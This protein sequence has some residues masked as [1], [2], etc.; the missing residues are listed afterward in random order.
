MNRTTERHGSAFFFLATPRALV[1]CA[2]LALACGLAS[3]GESP[4]AGLMGRSSTTST[5]EF[6]GRDFGGLRFPMRTV[7]GPVSFGAARVTTWSRE[8]PAT[9][10]TVQQMLLAGDVKVTLGV[11]RFSAAR[12]VVFIEKI[13]DA[14]D[15][16][17]AEDVPIPFAP[18]QSAGVYQIYVYFDRVSSPMAEISVSVQ[19]NRLPVRAVIE[20]EDGIDLRY[21]LL[22]Q[23]ESND[24]LVAEAERALANILRQQEGAET[25]ATTTPDFDSRKRLS[26]PVPSESR[27][28]LPPTANQLASKAAEDMDAT[29]LQNVAFT[30]PIFA[31]DGIFT[32]AP[33]DVTLISGTE[34]NSLLISNGLVVQYADTRSGRTLQLTAQRG[35]VFTDPTEIKDMGRLRASDVRGFYL[36][37]DVIASDGQYTLR[38]PKMFYDVRR[39]KA[40]VLDGVFW[41]YDQ[42]RKLPLYVRADTIRQKS[43]NE[44]EAKRARLASSAFFNPDFSIGTTTVTLT[45]RQVVSKPDGILPTVQSWTSGGQGSGSA[46][47]GA[48]APGQTTGARGLATVA[49]AGGVGTVPTTGY[50]METD[51]IT[52]SALMP[53]MVTEN[54]IDAKNITLN[55]EGFPF[56]YWPYYEGTIDEPLLRDLQAENRTGS[57]FAIKSRW[58]AYR[59][60]GLK[61]T[62]FTRAD[63][64]LDAYFSRG[65]GL[66]TNLA[67]AGPDANGSALMYGLFNDHGTDVLPTG[68]RHKYD[69]ENRGIVLMDHALALND[70]WT[71]LGEGAYQSDANFVE[72]FYPEMAQTRREFTTE[73]YLR[74]LEDNTEFT[75]N[76]KG[77]TNSFITNEYLLQ[78]QGYYVSKAPELQ[79][80]RQADPLLSGWFGDVLTWTQEYRAGMMGMK[81]DDVT[82]SYRGFSNPALSQQ[83]FGIDPNQTLAQSLQ[84]QGN[85][86]QQV[87]RFDTRQ[88]V[89]AKIEMGPVNFVPY[90]VVRLTGYDHNF[91]Q[92]SNNAGSTD[93][94]RYRLWGA[95]GGTLSTQIQRVDNSADSRLF[96]IHRVRHI[97]EPSMT[98]FTAATNRDSSTLPTYDENVEAIAKG[99]S[100][101]AGVNQIWQTQRGSP[102]H[103][104]SVD[105]FTLDANYVDSTSSTDTRSPVG[106]FFDFRPEL[107]SFGKYGNLDSAWRVTDA[108]TLTGGTVYDF[109]LNQQAR[110]SAGIIVQQTPDVTANV[111]FRYLNALDLTTLGGGLAYR[112]ANQ[113][114]VTLTASYDLTNNQLQ[115]IGAE[116]KRDFQSMRLGFNIAHSEISGQTSFGFT[117]TPRVGDARGRTPILGEQAQVR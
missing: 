115:G 117:L 107:S 35:V 38:G 57:G 83:I 52:A 46:P 18:D 11:Y 70:K 105:V 97:I 53:S 112:L 87:F 88:Q 92:F 33:G 40:I 56:F 104:Y 96:D 72:S 102:G 82:P 61:G 37:G 39:N 20:P 106:R 76:L 47:S 54:Y 50:E 34:E 89:D 62:P 95:T 4:M 1:C 81:F 7:R 59:L 66:G 85:I 9:G 67:W 15:E 21:D 24:P 90:G 19:A 41:T 29:T 99:S 68:E 93:D 23:G 5:D 113:Y 16:Q 73:L 6:S 110:T 17:E 27:S 116:V 75:T 80:L 30:G 42:Q 77:S 65:P 44:F 100:F 91:Q 74:R 49:D 48:T 28:Y 32:I 69:G 14:T 86:S 84:A 25:V 3:A 98:L 36:E 94:D 101:R 8:S 2:G 79:Y 78:S 26:A 22:I 103:Y 60:I 63:V 108:T 13:S 109:N 114:V 45:R 55:A 51:L 71:L 58:N 43:S 64:M 31:K 10:T 12:A 111:D